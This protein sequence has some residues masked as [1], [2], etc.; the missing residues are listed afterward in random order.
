MRALL[1]LLGIILIAVAAAYLL[2]P[3][4]Q[5]PTWMPGYEAGRAA[6][7]M[8]HGYAAGGVGVLLFLIGWFIGRR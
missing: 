8:K 2:I 3:A 4:D 1:F 6:T 7:R 5:L